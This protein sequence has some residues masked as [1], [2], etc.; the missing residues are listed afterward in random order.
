MIFQERGNSIL[1]SGE[2]VNEPIR[3]KA[4]AGSPLTCYAFKTRFL[5][6]AI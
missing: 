2:V 5:L 1:D 4:E 3:W 6:F